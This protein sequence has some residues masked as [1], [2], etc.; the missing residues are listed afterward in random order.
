MIRT[1]IIAAASAAVLTIS[2]TVFGQR[3]DHG[4]A[5][6]AKAAY[7]GHEGPSFRLMPVRDSG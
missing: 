6:Q 5:E 1:F 7:S 4:T 3:P 2:P